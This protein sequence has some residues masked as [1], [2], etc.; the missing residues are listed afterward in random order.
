MESRTGMGFPFL[1]GESRLPGE[2]TILDN[3]SGQGNLNRPGH[4]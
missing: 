4:L 1:A 3:R 2:S